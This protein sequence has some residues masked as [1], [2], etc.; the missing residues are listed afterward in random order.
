M[1]IKVDSKT[2]IVFDL[3]DTIYNELEFLRSAYIHIAR[4]LDPEDWRKL[5]VLMFSLYRNKEDVFGML[6]EQYGISKTRLIK[7]YREH[8]PNIV[9]FRGVVE[10]LKEIRSKG[11]QTGILT[12]GREIT[13]MNKIRALGIENLIDH[14]AI[15]EV[16]GSEKP[17]LNNYK[18]FM[19]KYAVAKYCYI[20]DNAKKDFVTPNS[21]GWKTIGLMDNG[22]NIHSNAYQYFSKEYLPQFFIQQISEIRII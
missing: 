7:D 4:Q 15:S 6:S 2:V 17:D 9:P 18:V 22:L 21:L 16:L 8:I 13:Q 11:G 3:D 5:Y 14:I 12:D 19:D 20:A 10:L 1:D